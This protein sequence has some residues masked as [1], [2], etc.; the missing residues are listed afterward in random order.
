[1]RLHNDE[2]AAIRSAVQ[3]H[4]GDLSAVWLS[5]SRLEDDARG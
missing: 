2:I 5:G 4:F 1:M 3:A